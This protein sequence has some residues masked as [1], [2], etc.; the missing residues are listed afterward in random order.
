MSD[1]AKCQSY[2]AAPGTQPYYQ[3]R[4]AIDQQRE[5]SSGLASAATPQ[6]AAPPTTRSPM[7]YGA[8]IR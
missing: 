2:G 4:L 3:C 7:T 1:D 5:Q 8:P 6:S